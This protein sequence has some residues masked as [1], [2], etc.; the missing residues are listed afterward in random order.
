MTKYEIY[1]KNLKNAEANGVPVDWKKAT[2]DMVLAASKETDDL[3]N[4]MKQL[5]EQLTV[6]QSNLQEEGEELEE[7]Q[8]P[9]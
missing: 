8:Q 9:Y 4:E 5:Q 1:V 7:S 3:R 2:E 6:A